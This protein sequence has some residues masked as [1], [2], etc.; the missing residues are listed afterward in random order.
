MCPPADSTAGAGDSFALA[1][2]GGAVSA[3]A[4]GVWWLTSKVL[5][6]VT[7]I[8]TVHT[9][10][11]L[12]ADGRALIH[13]TRLTAPVIAARVRAHHTRSVERT[14]PLAITAA[15]HGHVLWSTVNKELSR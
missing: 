14:T 8:V 11:Y 1:L 3:T 5:A 4:R 2:L 10:R 15:P 7:V 12:H 9:A 6:P 13:L